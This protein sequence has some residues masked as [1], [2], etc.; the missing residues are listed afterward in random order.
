LN[1]EADDF[2]NPYGKHQL[3]KSMKE[4]PFSVSKTELLLM[5]PSKQNIIVFE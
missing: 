3:L 4:F 5:N 2:K 1:F